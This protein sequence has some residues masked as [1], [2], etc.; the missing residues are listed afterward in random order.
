[1]QL[2]GFHSFVME[3]RKVHMYLRRPKTGAMIAVININYT[4]SSTRYNLPAD[5]CVCKGA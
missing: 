1:M 4:Y 3:C 2:V 5:V